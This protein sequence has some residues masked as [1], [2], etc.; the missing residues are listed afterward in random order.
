M[1]Q[2]FDAN[3]ALSA[4]AGDSD[5]LFLTVLIFEDDG[6]RDHRRRAVACGR[7]DAQT[8]GEQQGEGKERE[9]FHGG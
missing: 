2:T 6:K 5:G 4:R 1:S 3:Q 7:R 8:A 9:C